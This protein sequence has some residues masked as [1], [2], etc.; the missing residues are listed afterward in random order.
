MTDIVNTA[1]TFV[2]E[3]C[4]HASTTKGNLIQ[5]LEKKKACNALYSA[6]TREDIMKTLTRVSEKEKIYG[7]NFCNKQFSTRPGKCKHQHI[8]PQRPDNKT[9]QRILQLELKVREL[10]QTIAIMHTQYQTVLSNIMPTNTSSEEGTSQ[11]PSTSTLQAKKK[12]KISFSLRKSCWNEY[13]GSTIGSTK[14]LCCQRT[15]ISQLDFECGHV[16]AEAI[17]G[18]T[19]IS[20]LRPI[21]RSCNGSMGICDMRVYARESF[22]VDLN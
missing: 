17:G 3:R 9:E 18:E 22:G 7:C 13:V 12:K 1:E 11:Q 6:R 2:C 4:H 14:C 21:C 10:E 20:N 16:I 8:C 19:N 5:H 15:D